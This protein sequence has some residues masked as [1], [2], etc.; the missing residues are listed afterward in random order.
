MLSSAAAKVAS[1]SRTGI[2]IETSGDIG[3][4]MARRA[5][6]VYLAWVVT[7]LVSKLPAWRE[8]TWA[9]LALVCAIVSYYACQTPEPTR[10][11]YELAAAV[12]DAPPSQ[13]RRL[14]ER[15]VAP[16]VEVEISDRPD[17]VLTR[18]ELARALGELR[19]MWARGRGSCEVELHDVRLEPAGGG[20]TWLAATLQWSASQPSDPHAR[21]RP[22]RALFRESGSETSGGN[23]SG[24]T[25]QRLERVRVGPALRAEPEARP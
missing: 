2:K 3:N 18:D 22:L 1:A 17:E 7:A 20:G 25:L 8:L 5:S 11:A 4:G 6:A 14:I 19:S 10:T 21:P 15:H 24:D 16:Q 12:C 23:I 9:S 13:Q